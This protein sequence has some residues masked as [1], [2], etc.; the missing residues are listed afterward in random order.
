MESLK[1]RI[2]ELRKEG[3]TINEIVKLLGCAKATVSYHINKVGLGGT[4]DKL[5][6]GISDEII[7]KVILYK[8][9]LKTYPEIKTL[10]NISEDK[11]KKICR[12]YKINKSSN[13]FKRKVLNTDEVISYYLKVNSLKKTG[14]FF[15][16]DKETVKKYIPQ[17]L[18]DKNKVS[19]RTLKITKS[20]S[21]I[22]WRKRQKITLVDYKGGCCEKCGY[23]KSIAALQFHHKNPEEKDFTIGGS[24]YSIDRLKKEADKCMLVCANCHI[25]IHEELRN[26]F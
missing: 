10:L 11:L 19:N 1:V 3:A 9:E 4:R 20:Q 17:E 13:L 14:K 2:I 8:K 15:N 18:V 7:Q 12:I 21:V 26:N 23:N 22:N 5:L 6:Y 24:S 16:V 25:E